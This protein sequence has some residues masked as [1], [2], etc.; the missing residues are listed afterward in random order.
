MTLQPRHDD[1]AEATACH[2]VPH[3]HDPR[4]YRV[5]DKAVPADNGFTTSEWVFYVGETLPMFATFVVYSV[6][7]FGQLLPDAPDAEW[8]VALATAAGAAP[9][10]SSSS[11]AAGIAPTDAGGGAASAKSVSVELGHVDA[12]GEAEKSPLAAVRAASADA[13]AYGTPLQLA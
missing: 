7:H 3:R 6:W 10:P 13:R 4:S 9:P 12:T 5:A 1:D 11:A 8:K 2:C